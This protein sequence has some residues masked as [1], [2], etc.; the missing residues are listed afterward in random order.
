MTAIG[1]V[2]SLWRYPVKSMRGERCD[3]VFIGFPGV[4]GDRLFAFHSSTARPGLP[5]LTAREQRRMLCY[6]PRFREREKTLA[7]PNLAAAEKLAPGA[8]PLYAD[9]ID[10]QVE[11]ETPSGA[12]LAIDDPRLHELLREGVEG[13]PELTLRRS[14]RALTDC[15]PISLIS[16]Q[17]IQKLGEETAAPLDPRRFRAN[18][19]LNLTNAE[20]FAENRFVGRSLRLGSKV[21]LAILERD[22]RCMIITLDPETGEKMPAVLKSVA[23]K[24][25][26][27]A[28]VYAAVLVEGMVQPGDKV[29]LLD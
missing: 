10:L 20:G 24:H 19:Y 29:S 21:T 12:T 15:R 23:Q 28:G 18:L 9:P 2:E 8:S 3:A 11:V 5:Y 27:F 22:P 1:I 4:Y 26:G 14:E 17:S 25:E 16:S 13:E 7:P 6:Q